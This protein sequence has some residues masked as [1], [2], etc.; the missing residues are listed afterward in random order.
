MSLR[1]KRSN[2]RPHCER[3]EATSANVAISSK[4][5][6]AW[7][8]CVIARLGAYYILEKVVHKE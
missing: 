1:A 4:T 5:Q 6:M 3:S 2:P 7:A 8:V